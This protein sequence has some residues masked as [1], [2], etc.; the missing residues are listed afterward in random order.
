MGL[1]TKIVGTHSERELKRIEGI[2]QEIE[3]KRPYMMSL[4]DAQLRAQTNKFK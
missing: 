1:L 2:V 3:S 4:S